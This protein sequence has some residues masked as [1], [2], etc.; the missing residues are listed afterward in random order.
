[1]TT[2]QRGK[3]FETAFSLNLYR[4]SPHPCHCQRVRLLAIVLDTTNSSLTSY[5]IGTVLLT[6]RVRS[7][8]LVA[9]TLSWG[10]RSCGFFNS[11]SHID[12]RCDWSLVM[13]YFV[14]LG[15]LCT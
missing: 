7:S 6:N 12:S 8:L 4:S 14:A 2:W 1:M 3:V 10:I 13:N 15:L 11:I 9:V 5:T